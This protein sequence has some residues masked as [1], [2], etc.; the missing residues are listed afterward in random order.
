MD[1]YRKLLERINYLKNLAVEW[2]LG[3][4]IKDCLLRAEKKIPQ[5]EI[6]D[7]NNIR[8]M[9]GILLKKPKKP[10]NEEQF[11]I[12]KQN[13]DSYQEMITQILQCKLNLLKEDKLSEIHKNQSTMLKIQEYCI[14]PERF[15]NL[16]KILFQMDLT[17]V[18]KH[19]EAYLLQIKKYREFM[20][21]QILQANRNA[22]TWLLLAGDNRT[23]LTEMESQYQNILREIENYRR[24]EQEC[25]N[26]YK[27]ALA[28]KYSGYFNSRISRI[29]QKF[30]NV[31][32]IGGW[33]EHFADTERLE[34][35]SDEQAI[36]VRMKYVLKT[37]LEY[38]ADISAARYGDI[39][40]AAYIADFQ[41]RILEKLYDEM[42][43]GTR[44]CFAHL[45]S[46]ITQKIDQMLEEYRK[47]EVAI[48][49]QISRLEDNIHM[50]KP[51]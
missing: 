29:F 24:L 48:L 4:D 12:I 37:E 26:D 49:E 9:L 8:N 35:I 22:Y 23:M 41:M 32:I 5:D 39:F 42:R 13:V 30:I 3:E 7:S 33:N 44:E 31:H 18:R 51:L 19:L 10:K 47:E 11:H 46:K 25:L 45:L 34:N 38:E 27:E 2:D 21:D 36:R 1:I 15:I 20:A 17:D 14:N 28:E 16:K 43:K 6:A 50:L 40:D